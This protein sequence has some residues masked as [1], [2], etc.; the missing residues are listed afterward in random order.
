MIWFKVIVLKIFFG[1]I[2]NRESLNGWLKEKLTDLGNTAL[3]QISV[4]WN[5]IQAGTQ[6]DY[7]KLLLIIKWNKL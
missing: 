7:F 1:F 4:K 6:F 5:K 2:I 3:V